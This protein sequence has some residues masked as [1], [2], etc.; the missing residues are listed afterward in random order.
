MGTVE[1]V[2]QALQESSL[3]V[4]IAA[5]PWLFP[6]IETVHVVA[7]ALVIGSI[8]ML[9]LRLLGKRW[10]RFPVTALAGYTL[11]LT[12]AAFAVAA[13]S[14]GLMF[15][16]NAAVY[17]VNRAFQLKFLLI[18]AAGLNM[19]SFHAT[20]YKS[21]LSWQT[22]LPPPPRAQLAGCLSLAFWIGVVAAGRWIG[23][24]L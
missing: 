2:L 16:S 17:G 1:S 15:I 10:L 14:G 22:Q 5:S 8:S 7:I 13:V 23:F 20:T 4:A 19:L 18:A 21:V 24:T 11:P 3:G 6:T 9:D 12:W